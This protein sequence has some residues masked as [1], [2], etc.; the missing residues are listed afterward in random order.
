VWSAYSSFCK[1]SCRGLALS[2]SLTFCRRTPAYVFVRDADSV[3]R[4]LRCRNIDVAAGSFI[5]AIHS[6]VWVLGRH[7]VG[8]WCHR[9]YLQIG[10]AGHWYRDILWGEE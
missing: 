3:H 8:C 10:G 7:D 2:T 5:L 4:E 9:R 1:S 6:D